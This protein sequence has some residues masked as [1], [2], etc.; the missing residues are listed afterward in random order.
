MSQKAFE[1]LDYAIQGILFTQYFLG[2]GVRETIEYLGLDDKILQ[3]QLR[4]LQVQYQDLK[5]AK[6]PNEAN[7]ETE[8]IQP[9]L[10][11]LGFSYLRQEHA[12][13]GSKAIPDYLLFDDPARKKKA[14]QEPQKNFEQAI[15]VLEAKRFE[16]PLDK[17]GAKAQEFDSGTPSSQILRYLSNAEVASNGKI[18][19]GILTN[20]RQW[21]LYYH[22]AKSRTEGFIEF[23]LELIFVP[24]SAGLFKITQAQA[25]ELFKLFYLFLRKDAFVHTLR[26]DA[27][28]NLRFVMAV[29]S[30]ILINTYFW[31]A[32]L[33]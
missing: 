27:P 2:D 1:I 11:A 4:K 7:T 25:F 22:K 33:D 20:G 16:R 3:D 9:V 8:F 15:A 17:R 30:S 18:L 5:K 6:S 29:I 24:D 31:T 19:W 14:Q 13:Q 28:I 12:K 26:E 21:R 10:D 32:P 23:D